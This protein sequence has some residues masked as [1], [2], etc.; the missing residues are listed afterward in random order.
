MVDDNPYNTPDS[1]VRVKPDDDA[2]VQ[3]VISG[4]KLILYAILL[5]IGA[6]ILAA[7][8][9]MVGI[10]AF[11]AAGVMAISGL[12]K[13]CTGLRYHVAAIVAFCLMMIVP[14]L[15][16][17]VLVMINHKATARIRDAG[18]EVGLMGAKV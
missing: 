4:Q 17:V 5:N 2:E 15:N 16:L 7:R 11:L 13:V 18:Y 8:I 9:P 3:K 10:V 14:L 6:N 1:N 12:A